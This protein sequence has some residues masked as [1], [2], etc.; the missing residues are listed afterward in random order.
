MQTFN[1]NFNNRFLLSSTSKGNQIKWTIGNKFIKAD[2]MGYE[3]VAEIVASILESTISG[4][5]YVSYSPCI[6]V[7][8]NSYNFY[9][10]VSDIFIND[11][12]SLVT[13]NKI[14]KLY[15]GG[16]E[17]E[18]KH[19]K[20]LSGKQLISEVVNIC[21]EV[22]KIST[23]EIMEYLSNMFKIDAL[24]LNED[25][26]LN[27]ISFIKSD[28]GAYSLAPIFDNGLSLLS[29]TRDYPMGE[30]LYLL[31]RRVKAKPFNTDFI[32]QA[33]YF[34]DYDLLHIDIDCLYERLNSYEIEFKRKEFERA[35]N[36]LLSRLNLLKGVVWE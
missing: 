18:F 35:K 11:N 17:Q 8:D 1:I 14:L 9:G 3:S 6:I 15:Y 2:S 33:K 20:R 7:E 36:I 30:R 22:T 34:S 26:H 32:K 31:L 23:N 24:I 4:I 16:T 12:E 19:L 25:R 10:C 21:S 29:D 5:N 28:N 13:V 27:N